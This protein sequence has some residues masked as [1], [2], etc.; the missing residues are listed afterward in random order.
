MFNIDRPFGHPI[1]RAQCPFPELYL[2]KNLNSIMDN[3]FAM[4]P[5]KNRRRGH[6]FDIMLGNCDSVEELQQ[7]APS[8]LPEAS[9]LFKWIVETST[10]ALSLFDL[11]ETP[12]EIDRS[13]MN[14]M[15]KNCEG[16]CHW[17][18]GYEVP[19]LSKTP[20][21]VGVFYMQEGSDLVVVKEGQHGKL[22][23]EVPLEN[24]SSI[25]IST[26]ELLLHRPNVWHAIQ[27]HT[28]EI[29]RTCFAFHL[30]SRL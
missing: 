1:I 3:V 11:P 18:M 19:G 27:K 14:R 6:Y 12:L 22:L 2:D 9:E 7:F 23:S 17:H 15:Y 10:K 16:R 4:E 5:I 29:P 30:S 28:S 21:L 8:N 26:G 25:K 24:Q 20:S 13:A